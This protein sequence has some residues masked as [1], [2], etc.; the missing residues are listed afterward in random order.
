G[1]LGARLG[2]ALVA[3]LYLLLAAPAPAACAA[4]AARFRLVSLFFSLRRGNLLERHGSGGLR[5]RRLLGAR[6]LAT[7]S[8]VR[9]LLSGSRCGSRIRARPKSACLPR[10]SF[11]ETAD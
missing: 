8:H 7:E 11:V 1:C 5:G 4:A 2:A 6:L 9:N 10:L 3:P